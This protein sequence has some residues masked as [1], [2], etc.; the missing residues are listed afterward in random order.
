MM[1]PLAHSRNPSSLLSPYRLSSSASQLSTNSLARIIPSAG[2]KSVFHPNMDPTLLAVRRFS[3]SNTGISTPRTNDD[4]LLA[5]IASNQ[6][7][8][9]HEQWKSEWTG[10]G[11]RAAMVSV[12]C[13]YVVDSQ[14]QLHSLEHQQLHQKL[15][16]EQELHQRL[17][18]EQEQARHNMSMLQALSNNLLKEL[19]EQS[20]KSPEEVLKSAFQQS[21]TVGAVVT[22]E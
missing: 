17:Q 18:Q 12:L 9:Q 10:H 7:K 8:Q 13:C 2:P 4:S 21:V 11:L 16:Q 6:K 3:I 14:K 19:S 15:Q 22:Q 5:Q 1:R 20:G